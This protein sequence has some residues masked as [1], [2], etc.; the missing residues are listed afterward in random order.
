MLQDAVAH[1][2]P[3]IGR[4]SELEEILAHRRNLRS[5]YGLPLR[6]ADAP[7]VVA[8]VGQIEQARACGED[9]CQPH[10]PRLTGDA[11]A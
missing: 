2:P 5:G 3:A 10:R 4:L 8:A 11:C 6:H 7:A 9:F 1:N